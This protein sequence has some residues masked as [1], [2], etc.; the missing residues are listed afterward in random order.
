MGENID[1]TWLACSARAPLDRATVEA[2]MARVERHYSRL[3]DYPLAVSIASTDHSCVAIAGD[4]AARCRWPHF[5]DGEQFAIAT[6]YVPAGWSRLVSGEHDRA[7]LA[8]AQAVADDPAAAI[9][10][11]S[12]P[13]AVAA[14][15]RRSGGL[16]VIN[17]ALGAARAFTLTTDGLTIWSNRPGAL[18]VFAGIQPAADPEGWRV[19]AGAGWPLGGSSPI[20]G[21]KRLG[22]GTVCRADAAGTVTFEASHAVRSLVAPNSSWRELAGPAAEQMVSQ[23]AEVASLWPEQADVDLSGGMDSRVTAAATIAAGI[24][25][26]YLTSNATPGEGKVARELMELQGGELEHR[27][28]RRK[29]GSATPGTPLLERAANLHLLHDGVRHPQKLRGKMTLPRPRPQGAKFSGHGGEIAHGFFYKSRA[30]IR[31]LRFRPGALPKRLDRF[32]AQG[33]DATREDAALAARSAVESILDEGRGYGLRG[34]VLLD[35][36]YLVDRFAH[37]SG[38]ATDSERSVLFAVPGAVAAAFAMSPRERVEGRLHEHLTARLVP[39]WE[40][41]EYFQETE[42]KIARSKRERV[43]EVEADATVVESI[44]AAGGPWTELWDRDVALRE[45]QALRAGEGNRKAET[46]FEGIVYRATF[47]QHLERLGRSARA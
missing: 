7:P 45:W 36:F 28:R 15:D 14:L 26:R 9:A 19:L 25:A 30:E 47:D 10:A 16:V 38:L 23:A 29:A 22:P 39:A 18:A 3:V 37:R 4:A 1:P 11:L 8:L 5:A 44:L 43:W 17:D 12:P 46:L 32:F 40:G 41:V 34:P 20:A 31:G 21:V 33:H 2:G 27:I 35:W 42:E 13:L 24:D 6:A